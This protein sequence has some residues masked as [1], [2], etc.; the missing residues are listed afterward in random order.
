M[1][2][3]KNIHFLKKPSIPSAGKEAPMEIYQSY[4]DKH[5]NVYEPI[6]TVDKINETFM[7]TNSN[8]IPMIPSDLG[9]NPLLSTQ[10]H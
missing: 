9:L 6:K 1:E 5:L 7:P 3:K 4:E 2:I 10:L 8:N